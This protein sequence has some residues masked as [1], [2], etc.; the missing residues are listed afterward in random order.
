MAYNFSS[1]ISGNCCSKK[2]NIFVL[3]KLI[4]NVDKIVI[5][6][7]KI[8]V[9]IEVIIENKL[10]IIFPKFLV[11]IVIIFF[12]LLSISTVSPCGKRFK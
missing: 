5:Q 1:H 8:I 6:T 10:L 7:Y 11:A 2:F 3:S 4:K 12:I 9:G